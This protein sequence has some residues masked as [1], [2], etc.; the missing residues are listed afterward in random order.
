MLET[1]ANLGTVGSGIGI[2]CRRLYLWQRQDADSVPARRL[3]DNPW[4]LVG[5]IMLMV[6]LS[7]IDRAVLS[8]FGPVVQR[9]LG[10]SDSQMGL[11][12]GLGFIAPFALLTL[13]VGWAIDHYNRVLILLAGLCLWSAMTAGC[14]LVSSFSLLLLCRGGVGAGGGGCSTRG[15]CV[16]CRIDFRRNDAAER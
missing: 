2:Q 14:G 3:R 1:G 10:I 5:I 16:D 7:Y 6:I 13:F 12:Y 11:L 8:L 4:Y 15:I 9:D